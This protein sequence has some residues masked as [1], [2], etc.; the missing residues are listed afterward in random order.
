[1]TLVVD[2]QPVTHTTWGCS[3]SSPCRDGLGEQGLVLLA[4]N[5]HEG[6]G[7]CVGPCQ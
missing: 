2:V 6:V 5:V 4:L 7:D 1:V 3:Y